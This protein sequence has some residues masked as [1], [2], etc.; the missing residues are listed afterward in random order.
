M[1]QIILTIRT[2]SILN[3]KW[4]RAC[5]EWRPAVD[6]FQSLSEASGEVQCKLWLAD[7]LD[8]DD[9]RMDDV[10]AMDIYDIQKQQCT[11]IPISVH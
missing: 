10:T 8:A 1:Q 6:A 7:A 5:K 11:F 4:R 9:E 3:R 2:A